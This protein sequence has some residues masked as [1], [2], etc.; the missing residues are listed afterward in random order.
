MVL[1]R[2]AFSKLYVPIEVE[3]RVKEIYD[4]LVET[5]KFYDTNPTS[6][7]AQSSHVRNLCEDFK[8]DSIYDVL[9]ITSFATESSFSMG[10]R[11][12]TKYRSSL[13]TNNVEAFLNAQNLLFGYLKDQ[14][15]EECFEVMK[16]VMPDDVDHDSLP[17]LA[18]GLMVAGCL[19]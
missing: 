10:G 9:P 4:A 15:V 14:K 8:V 11:V 6:S 2:S 13:H 3:A 18:P 17:R 19:W 5:Y 16:D 7:S 12:L 1:V